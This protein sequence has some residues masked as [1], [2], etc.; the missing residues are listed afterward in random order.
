MLLLLVFSDGPRAAV[1]KS[2]ILCNTSYRRAMD[3]KSF[4]RVSNVLSSRLWFVVNV[5][6]DPSYILHVTLFKLVIMS[7]YL[8]SI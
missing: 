5:S 8:C 1:Q 7:V 3:Y 2:V 4:R 6:V